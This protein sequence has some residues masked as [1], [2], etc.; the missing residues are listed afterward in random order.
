MNVDIRFRQAV[1]RLS[2]IHLVGPGGVGK[3][4]VG[5]LVARELGWSFL[6]LDTE[7]MNRIA[8]IGDFI[9]EHGYDRYQEANSELAH[10]VV[11]TIDRPYIAAL[12]S[13]FLLID[14]RP[15]C[16]YRNRRLVLETGTSIVIMPSADIDEATDIV[17]ARQLGRGFGLIADRE[18]EKFRSR[19]AAYLELGDMQIFSSA[20][21]EEI[22][23]AIVDRLRVP[24]NVHP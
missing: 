18:R 21:P 3:S 8:H 16:G 12:S 11:T 10:D 7:F 22:A 1:D 19:F 6:D 2:A 9:R 13:G 14:R 20:P 5:R 4:T 15:E 24:S 23:A 17:V